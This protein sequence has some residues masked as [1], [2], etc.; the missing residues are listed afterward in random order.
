M[1]RRK[2]NTRTQRDLERALMKAGPIDARTAKHFQNQA[3]AI[4]ITDAVSGTAMTVATPAIAGAAGL[5]VAAAAGTTALASAFPVGTIIVAVPIVVSLGLSVAK[6]QSE[7]NAQHLTKDQK[8]LVKYIQKYQK[9]KSKWRVEKAK[10]WLKDYSKHLK[11]GSKK[12]IAPWDGNK[13]ERE[14]KGWKAKKAELEMKLTAIYIAEYKQEPP[15]PVTKKQ[16]RKS[17]SIIRKIQNLQKKAGQSSSA[18]KIQGN[19][20]LLDK[21]LL[22]RQTA[23]MLQRPSEQTSVM[24]RQTP[25]PPQS[26]A[27]TLQES[28]AVLD[29]TIEIAKEK[30]DDS[31]LALLGLGIGSLLGITALIL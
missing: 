26:I 5:G 17:R 14:E 20:L 2:R 3:N 9:R 16:Q 19:K 28:P 30:K 27:K 23:R 4:G 8:T 7:K 25:P 12:T 11:N 13:R 24:K 10:K 15:K 18:Y 31:G 21:P 29:D 1:S 6:G 22:R